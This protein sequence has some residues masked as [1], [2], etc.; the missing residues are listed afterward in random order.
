MLIRK[1]VFK[2]HKYI[3][4]C[5]CGYKKNNNDDRVIQECELLAVNWCSRCCPECA[6][7]PSQIPFTSEGERIYT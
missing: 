6:G 7:V 4:Q 5:K 2:K 3:V 1:Y